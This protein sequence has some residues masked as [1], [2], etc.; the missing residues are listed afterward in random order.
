ML[1]LSTGY[2]THSFSTD[3][4][5]ALEQSLPSFKISMKGGHKQR[6]A[7]PP[8]AAKEYI[9]AEVYHIPDI[10]SLVYIQHVTL[11]D[12]RECLYAY[13][14]ALQLLMFHTN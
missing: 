6:L 2:C 5:E 1:N 11:D 3:S 4:E 10:L 7:E 8:W 12:V 9:L 14:Q 13:R